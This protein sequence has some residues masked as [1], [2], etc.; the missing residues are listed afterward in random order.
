M[1]ARDV[2]EQFEKL[3]EQ[4]G[5]PQFTRSDN[6]P[7]FVA[8]VVQKWIDEQGFETLFVVGRFHLSGI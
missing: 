1:T 5:I 4:R 7:E 6:D 2:T 3:V 8:K